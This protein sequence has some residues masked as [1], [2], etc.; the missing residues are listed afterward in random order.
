M[1]SED[2]QCYFLMF[3]IFVLL[4]VLIGI[5]YNKDSFRDLFDN[6]KLSELQNLTVPTF[7]GSKEILVVNEKD[8]DKLIGSLKNKT[9]L[10]TA[11]PD[12]STKDTLRKIFDKAD[13]ELAQTGLYEEFNSNGLGPNKKKPT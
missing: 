1:N 11:E 3:I 5:M 8:Y 13:K 6:V 4:L 12:I 2:G 10:R 9:T 7:D